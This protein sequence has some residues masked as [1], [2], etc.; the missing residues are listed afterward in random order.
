MAKNFDWVEE[1]STWFFPSI[2]ENA[3]FLFSLIL[4]SDTVSY[5]CIFLW[6]FRGFFKGL[7]LVGE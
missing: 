1:I 5:F 3:K 6:F 7:T 2:W 4:Y